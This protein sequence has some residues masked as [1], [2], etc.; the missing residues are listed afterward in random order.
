MNDPHVEYLIYT[1]IHGDSIKYEVAEPFSEETDDYIVKIEDGLARLYPQ[2]HYATAE[3]AKVAAQDFVSR[4]NFEV[5]LTGRDDKFK[6]KYAHAHVIDRQPSPAPPGVVSVAADSIGFGFS[7]TSVR[8]TKVAHAYPSLPIGRHLAVNDPHVAM[9]MERLMNYRHH[10][11]HLAA[12][13]YFCLT[14]V[15]D[16]L[17]EQ[18]NRRKQAARHYRITKSI[19]DCIGKLCAKGGGGSARKADGIAKPFDKKETRFLEMAV[20]ALIRRVAE[21]SQ[22]PSADLPPIHDANLELYASRGVTEGG[23]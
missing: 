2:R 5:E 10:R 19:L 21:L 4:W 17:G 11:E 3:E 22:N 9:M 16:S 12:M 23:A 13:A 1:V 14:V 20:Q 8:V 18:R 6:L 7:T 15:E